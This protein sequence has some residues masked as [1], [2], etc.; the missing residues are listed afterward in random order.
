MIRFIKVG[1]VQVSQE[2]FADKYITKDFNLPELEKFL[3]LERSEYIGLEII[4][5]EAG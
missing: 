1:T 3:E 4:K 5:D 2:Q